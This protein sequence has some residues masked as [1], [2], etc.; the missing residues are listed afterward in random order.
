MLHS[1]RTSAT[2]AALLL[3]LALLLSHGPAAAAGAECAAQAPAFASDLC[4]GHMG[5]P[6][7]EIVLR[8]ALSAIVTDPCAGRLGVY[9][10][11]GE[12]MMPTLVTETAVPVRCWHRR[13][14]A[15]PGI[16]ID[17]G[18]IVVFHQPLAQNGALIK[19]VIGLPGDLIEEINGMISLNGHVLGRRRGA[20]VPLPAPHLTLQLFDEAL[21]N[22][23]RYTI[24]KL[25][26][27]ARGGTALRFIVPP[28]HIFVLGDNRD[29]SRD[30]RAFGAVPTA[31]IIGIA[32][33]PATR[34][35]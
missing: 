32:A 4:A 17:A 21:P 12:S 22:G 23:R 18:D 19:R 3:L 24:L 6:Q 20:E 31:D 14:T 27:S 28:E 11:D 2:H 35:P 13:I 16:K 8:T 9:F 30:S 25:A 29:N 1:P 5:A 34:E 7:D 26:D 15:E 33:L 10:V